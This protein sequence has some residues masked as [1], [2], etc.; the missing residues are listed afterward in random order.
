MTYVLS[1]VA[2]LQDQ[3]LL[4]QLLEFG[5]NKWTHLNLRLAKLFECA[6]RYKVTFNLVH[7]RQSLW[8]GTSPCLDRMYRLFGVVEGSK[9]GS[10]C[11]FTKPEVVIIFTHRDT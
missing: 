2:W 6:C 10:F 3:Q 5:S 9:F 7:A 4:E 1:T 11:T 8:I